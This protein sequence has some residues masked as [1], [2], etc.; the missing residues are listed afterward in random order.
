MIAYCP[1]VVSASV[2]HLNHCVD[3]EAPMAREAWDRPQLLRNFSIVRKLDG[4]AWP[5]GGSSP[6]CDLRLAAAL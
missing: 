6:L 5:P 4:Q 2:V 1:Q 3:M